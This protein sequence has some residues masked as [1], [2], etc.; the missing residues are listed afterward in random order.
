VIT[1]VPETGTVY[2]GAGKLDGDKNG[3]KKEFTQANAIPGEGEIKF[4]QAQVT[5]EH[6]KDEVI[7]T[8]TRIWQIFDAK[9]PSIDKNHA[10]GIWLDLGDYYQAAGLNPE[11]LLTEP[12]LKKTFI[13]QAIESVAASLKSAEERPA[14]IQAASID[15][16]Q[17]SNLK[18]H[19][20]SNYSHKHLRG[21][22]KFLANPEL[23]NMD[24]EILDE[25]RNKHGLR[26]LWF[27]VPHVNTAA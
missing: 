21:A 11:F 8:T 24:L 14:I 3:E 1:I 23:L 22:A 2:L 27:A 9:T 20:S 17:L 10:D 25:L 5:E 6:G 26:N 19:E 4:L 7:R 18:G 16:E 12:E 13:A 15:F